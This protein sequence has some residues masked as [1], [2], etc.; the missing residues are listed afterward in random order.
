M[1]IENLEQSLLVQ[2]SRKCSQNRIMVVQGAEETSV[3][4]DFHSL[5]SNPW[6][7]TWDAERFR[8]WFLYI[9]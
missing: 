4:H 1:F 3:A 2:Y 6:A 7:C 5:E 8:Q 9:V